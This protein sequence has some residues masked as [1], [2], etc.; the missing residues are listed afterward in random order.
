LA[1]ILL[2]QI[3]HSNTDIL[4]HFSNRTSR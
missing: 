4:F 3:I 2:L 1:T